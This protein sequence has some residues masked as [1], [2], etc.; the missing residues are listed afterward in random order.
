MCSEIAEIVKDDAEVH[1]MNNAMKST[2]EALSPKQE[3]EI[4]GDIFTG[5]WLKAGAITAVQMNDKGRTVF[6]FKR[7]FKA[8]DAWLG[9]SYTNP[10][11]KG[12]TVQTI[13]RYKTLEEAKDS[14]YI[15]G[16]S[17]AN[18]MWF[19]LPDN[20]KELAAE[21]KRNKKRYKF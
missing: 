16:L 4:T 11:P 5:N 1:A 19:P 17:F 6:A 15:D 10:A 2:I 3:V 18:S 7:G 20:A 14:R 8:S 12:K 9:V 13:E 21:Q